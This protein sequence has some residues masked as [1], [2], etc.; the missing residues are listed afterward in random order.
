MDILAK[1]RTVLEP[2]DSPIESYPSYRLAAVLIPIFEKELSILF[3]LRT[4]NVKHHK[5]QVSFPGGRY[6]DDDKNI[7]ETALRETQEEVGIER[8]EIKL[9]GRL[10]STVTISN[11][12]VVPIVGLIRK[13]IPIRTNTLEVE[14]CFFAPLE[15][16]LKPEN[17]L[18]GNFDGFFLPYYKFSN[19]K[20]WGITGRILTDLINRIRS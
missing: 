9:L 11:Y 8:N 20:I 7:I 4:Q 3:T 16:L 2:I 19:F 1:I 10:N 15:E 5:G 6:D 13:I 18:K 17:Y 14:H 12:H